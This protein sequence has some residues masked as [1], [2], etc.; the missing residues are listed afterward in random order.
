MPYLIDG[1]NLI[2]QL[3][4]INLDDPNDEAKLVQKLIGFAAR[5]G[6]RCTVVFDHGIPGGQ[7]TMSKSKVTVIFAAARHTNADAIILNRIRQEHNPQALII[8]SSDRE[9]RKVAR[10]RRMVTLNAAEFIRELNKPPRKKEE[11]KTDKRADAV[12][13][14]VPKSEV[15]EWLDI[16][17]SD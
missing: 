2:G 3:P 12:H 16:F 6:K 5:T 13:V 7:S 17:D 9:V 11:T 15:E 1:H 10:A 8:V 14:H 4:D